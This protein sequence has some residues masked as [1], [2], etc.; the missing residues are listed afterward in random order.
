MCCQRLCRVSWTLRVQ[1]GERLSKRLTASCPIWSSRSCL[2]HSLICGAQCFVFMS[3]E[4]CCL[5]LHLWQPFKRPT[6]ILLSF[7]Q[8]LAVSLSFWVN[9]WVNRSITGADGSSFSHSVCTSGLLLCCCDDSVAG[10]TV[11]SKSFCSHLNVFI[12]AVNVE[13]FGACL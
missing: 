9:T 10:V 1:R 7:Y 3:T 8:R 5:S 11:H 4:K 2:T 6:Q 12:S 13:V